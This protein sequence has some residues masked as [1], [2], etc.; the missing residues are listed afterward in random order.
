MEDGNPI[1]IKMGAELGAQLLDK[2]GAYHATEVLCS[3]I[4]FVSEVTKNRDIVVYASNWLDS[5]VALDVAES[6]TMGSVQDEVDAIIVKGTKA[7]AFETQLL[8]GLSVTLPVPEFVFHATHL[9]TV[10]RVG[11]P[12]HCLRCGMTTEHKSL[13]RGCFEPKKEG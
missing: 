11:S 7:D 6:I 8:P 9:W 1:N 10:D 13:S 3:A 12:A 4:C 5:F 2:L